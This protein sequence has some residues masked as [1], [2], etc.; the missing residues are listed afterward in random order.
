MRLSLATAYIY[1]LS[2]R[3]TKRKLAEL[4]IVNRQFCQTVIV[5]GFVVIKKNKLC[6]ALPLTLALNTFMAKS[7]HE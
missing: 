4:A 5:V 7:L 3:A 2:K 1:L 6:L